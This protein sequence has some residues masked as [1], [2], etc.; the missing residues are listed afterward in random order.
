[1]WDPMKT[2]LYSSLS[3][4]DLCPRPVGRG[5]GRKSQKG[6]YSGPFPMLGFFPFQ[7]IVTGWL[8]PCVCQKIRKIFDSPKEMN[9]VSTKVLLLFFSFSVG[10]CPG[11]FRIVMGRHLLS[12]CY[13]HYI[14]S[15]GVCNLLLGIS[16]EVTSAT[17]TV[18]YEVTTIKNGWL[19]L[20]KIRMGKWADWRKK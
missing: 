18:L 1:M 11:Y 3:L 12:A 20:E 16:C 7:K 2:T 17:H 5:T 14:Q 10:I 9:A 15:K 6:L 4:R 8:V 13:A 19:S